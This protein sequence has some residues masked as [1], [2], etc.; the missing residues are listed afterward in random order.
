MKHSKPK[1]KN[2]Q[3]ANLTVEPWQELPKWEELPKMESLPEPW[4]DFPTM[5]LNEDWP[6]D[7]PDWDINPK[8]WKEMED[9]CN[10]NK[11]HSQ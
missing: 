1:P 7:L 9:W 10:G 2:A 11:K 6:P 8:P 5:N 4:Q 3:F